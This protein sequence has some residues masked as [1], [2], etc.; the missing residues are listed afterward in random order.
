MTWSAGGR[1]GF[2]P[3]QSDICDHALY[4]KQGLLMIAVLPRFDPIIHSPARLTFTK[5]LLCTWPRVRSRGYG[6]NVTQ[7]CFPDASGLPGDPGPQWVV[8]APG[9]EGGPWRQLRA[10]QP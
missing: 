9:E 5:Y 7:P 8:R 1:A 6:A 2:E 3:R 10:P 4:Q